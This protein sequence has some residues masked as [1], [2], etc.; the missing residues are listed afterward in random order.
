ML[1]LGLG[2]SVL[3]AVFEFIFLFLFFLR[4]LGEMTVAPG[5]PTNHTISLT[6]PIQHRLINDLFLRVE[7]ELSI[8]LSG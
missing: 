2:D 5:E 4:D 1:C 7:S 3:Q 8:H 6:P